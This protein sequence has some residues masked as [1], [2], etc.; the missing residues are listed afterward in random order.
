MNIALHIMVAYGFIG[1]GFSIASWLEASEHEVT[2]GREPHRYFSSIGM[3]FLFLWPMFAI[4]CYRAEIKK[5]IKLIDWDK[6]KKDS[7]Q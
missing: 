7:G 6:F 3:S 5:S 1:I 2:E 4:Y